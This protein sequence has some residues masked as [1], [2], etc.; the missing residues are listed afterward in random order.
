MEGVG[1]AYF[2]TSSLPTMLGGGGAGEW[3]NIDSFN[4]HPASGRWDILNVGSSASIN[5]GVLN[6][7]DTGDGTHDY[8]RITRDLA[9]QMMLFIFGLSL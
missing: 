8:Y 5:D 9:V 1:F 4:V 7:T 6:I 3:D 2:P